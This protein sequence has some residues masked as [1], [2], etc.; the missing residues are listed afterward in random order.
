M[1]ASTTSASN[2]TK[3]KFEL[4][5]LHAGFHRTGSMSLALAL[6]ILGLGPVWHVQRNTSQGNYAFNRKGLSW[7][8]KNNFEK[9]RQL[10]KNEHVDFNEWL[11]IIQCPCIMDCPTILY[12]DKIFEQF[13]DCKVIVPCFEFEKWYKSMSFTIKTIS[14]SKLF[15]F[16]SLFIIN[17]RLVKDYYFPR[18]F[19]N[20]ID[21]FLNDEKVARK[22][23]DDQLSH[24]SKIVPKE[25]LLVFD[26]RDGWEPLCKFLN[27][28]IPKVPFPRSN[29]QKNVKKRA[30]RNALSYVIIFYVLPFIVLIVTLAIAMITV[31]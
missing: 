26:I 4:K 14:K 29:S 22:Y 23:Y 31:T 20:Q 27:K 19:N 10:D 12:F 18:L 2:V 1:S 21:L 15:T 28:P 24:I 6:E 7:W 11:E 8:N 13:P 3:Q 17:C 5:V 9:F 30:H 16:I 25:S